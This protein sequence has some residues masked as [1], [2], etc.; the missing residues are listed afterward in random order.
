MKGKILLV[1]TAIW[2][3]S[4]MMVCVSLHSFGREKLSLDERVKAQ[5]AIE[6]VYYSHRIWPKENSDAK[7][8]FEKVVTRAILEEKVRAYLSCSRS[9]ELERK[10]ALTKKELSDE[11]QRM[12]STSSNK[13]V[14]DEIFSALGNNEILLEECLARPAIVQ[15]FGLKSSKKSISAWDDNNAPKLLSGT[16][17]TWSPTSQIS[18]PEARHDH[19]AIWT[20]AE[21]IIWGGIPAGLSPLKS[22][23][24]Y[25]P[26]TNTW[27]PT[28]DETGNSAPSGRTGF[29]AVWTG[30]K[31][32]IWGGESE[33]TYL[34]NGKQYDPVTDLWSDYGMGGGSPPSARKDHSAI[35]TGETMIIWGGTNG[36][37]LANGN[38]YTASTDSWSSMPDGP[39]PHSGHKGFWTGT[40][41]IIWGGICNIEY[42]SVLKFD[43]GTGIWTIVPWYL[44]YPA[45]SI[46]SSVIWTGN[47]IIE[48]GGT[49]C[50]GFPNYGSNRGIIYDPQDDTWV[51]TSTDNAPSSR[52]GH[53]AVWTG[54][55][56][57]LWGGAR[58]INYPP[59]EWVC[60]ND[61]A[62]FNPD[63]NSW[64]P[65]SNVGCPEERAGHTAVWTD[66]EMIV[67]GG[68]DYNDEM[69]TNLNSGG[70]YTAPLVPCHSLGIAGAPT[71]SSID[72][73]SLT[74][75]WDPVT[76][77]NGYD[78]YRAEVDDC[79]AVFK[80]NAVPLTGTSFDDTGLIYGSLYLYQI[81]A[82]NTLCGLSSYGPCTS[83]VTAICGP[84]PEVA[85]GEWQ[86]IAMIWS[87]ATSLTWPVSY[88]CSSGYKV[89]MG[90]QA[91][92]PN[93]INSEIDSCVRFESASESENVAG[94]L[95]EDPSSVEGRL[96]WYLVGG[97]NPYGAGSMGNATELP[98]ELN[99]SGIPCF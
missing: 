74:V 68:Q 4:L 13:A 66:T 54:L 18:C 5:E 38:I 44:E 97:F 62:R 81:V 23:G 45:C 32:I 96:Y 88:S 46:G 3:A 53:T 93:L 25:Y 87:D 89:F 39:Y 10:H 86:E 78:L 30:S 61:G 71:F 50:G 28:P 21:M 91:Q 7:P 33:G 94:N 27:V 12:K 52:L 43:P 26:S 1:K 95:T 72:C 15:R 56:M 49:G 14:L 65:I 9:V 70:R 19:M 58:F 29:S 6:R 64:M 22:G 2:V 85:T 51:A 37:C 11:L 24:K 69:F 90:T 75:T 17:N 79:T 84:P 36:T 16:P 59:G 20:G 31:L 55:E 99:S 42:P 92:L 83:V 76:E 8:P 73:T 82:L 40:Q 47:K 77:A 80:V 35:W 63:T 98:R 41:M 34:D 48:W 60:Y 57:V 67:W